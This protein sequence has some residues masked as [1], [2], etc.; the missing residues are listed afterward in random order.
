MLQIWTNIHITNFPRKIK[1]FTISNGQ[2]I[3][4]L[5][6][7]VF[8]RFALMKIYILSWRLAAARDAPFSIAL[9]IFLEE[10]LRDSLEDNPLLVTNFA[11]SPHALTI[12]QMHIQFCKSTLLTRRISLYV[13]RITYNLAYNVQLNLTIW[14]QTYYCVSFDPN[15]R[16]IEISR[17][18]PTP[19]L[20]YTIPVS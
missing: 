15:V 20:Q 11:N 8:I 6:L 1:L 13:T 16:T 17:R 2:T 3:F 18:Y 5:K 4:F 12:C 19:E 7:C 10:T 9:E 14:S